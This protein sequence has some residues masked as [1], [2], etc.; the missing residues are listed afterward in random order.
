M[1]TRSIRADAIVQGGVAVFLFAPQ[2]EIAL[3]WIRENVQA[4]AQWFGDA[5]AVEHR[6]ALDLAHGMILDGLKLA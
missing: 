6:F 5:L 3:E 2:T 4:D 1:A